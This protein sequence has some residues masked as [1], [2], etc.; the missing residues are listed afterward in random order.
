MKINRP[1]LATLLM[2]TPLAAWADT[3][4]TNVGALQNVRVLSIE[5][6]TMRY[7]T[8]TGAEASRDLPSVTRIQV[9]NE[10]IFNQAEEAYAAGQWD[11]ATSDYEKTL[12]STNKP[13]LKEWTSFRLLETADKS[14]DFSAATTAWIAL[15]ISNPAA[16]AGRQPTLPPATSTYLDT[17]A[18]E[19][20]KTLQGKLDNQ[21]RGELLKFVLDIYQKKNDTVKAIDAADR[22]SKITGGSGN[23]DNPSL[24]ITLK[25]NQARIAMNQNDYAKVKQEIESIAGV[26]EQPQQQAEALY[27]LAEADRNLAGD[28]PAKL[29]DAALAYMRV[30][31]HFPDDT[32]AGNALVQAGLILEK[33][34]QTDQ[35]RKLYEQGQAEYPTSKA[36][37]NFER[38]KKADP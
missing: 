22:L 13:W 23:E 27:L 18:D 34:G 8:P 37:E 14:G 38:L 29:Q 7:I 3:L 1:I 9:E 26:L 16:A 28:D 12:R 36:R 21:Q 4:Y 2:F 5:G 20:E 33:L 30:V 35:A 24:L 25:F 31:A 6:N 19:I 11:A 15:L 17:A 32:Q 10:P